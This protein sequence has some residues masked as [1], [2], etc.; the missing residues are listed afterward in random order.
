MPALME[1]ART[2][3]EFHQ[4]HHEPR[5]TDVAIG[6]GS[7]DIGV[8]EHAADLYR[9]GRF[10]LIV[11]TGANAPTTVND[12]PRGEAVE[13]AE[14]AEELG[15]PASAL[16]IEPRA[17]NTGE[18]IAFTRDLLENEG[19]TPRTAT[20]I[21]RPYQQR[22]AYATARKIWP[23]LEVTCSARV[24]ELPDYIAGIGS[25]RRVLD[26]L[27]GDTQRLWVYAD[28]GFAAPQ[29]IDDD[30]RMRRTNDSW[31]LGT[32][33]DCLNRTHVRYD[34]VCR[35][36]LLRTTPGPLPG[37]GCT[38]GCTAADGTIRR[39]CPASSSSGSCTR[40][41]GAPG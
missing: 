34:E 4:M 30:T 20:L 2:L 24:Q 39:P 6:L 9:Q 15:V 41:A 5:D 40:A 28:R 7:H 29:Q 31:L 21:S 11:F 37:T 10:P 12:F 32:P 13:F 38:S 19:I 17:T 3:W 1:D 14:R 33:A 26:M 22:R 35:P 23:D 36:T 18:N 25:T 16:R 8:A 27:V